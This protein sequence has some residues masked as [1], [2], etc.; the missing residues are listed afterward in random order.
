[1]EERHVPYIVRHPEWALRE[2]ARRAITAC[3]APGEL[4]I[5]P[6]CGVGDVLVEAIKADRM[7]IG[8]EYEKYWAD[9]ARRRIESVSGSSLARIRCGRP[10]RPT[11]RR[12]HA[13]Q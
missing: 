13:R 2:I 8:I 7:A 12:S 5:D 11:R 9:I 4:I 6:M 1:M 3:T 10:R